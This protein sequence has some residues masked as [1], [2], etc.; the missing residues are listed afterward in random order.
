MLEGDNDKNLAHFL[1]A[2]GKKYEV[3]RDAATEFV[4]HLAQTVRDEIVK[5][6]EWSGDPAIES[7]ASVIQ[8]R[9]LRAGVAFLKELDEVGYFNG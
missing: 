1:A 5:F 2:Y 4:T 8:A 7:T 9:V 3:E 6:S